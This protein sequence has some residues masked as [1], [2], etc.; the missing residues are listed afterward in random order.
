MSSQIPA[1]DLGLFDGHEV[2][3]T[4]VRIT[5]AGDGLS[6]SMAIEP[7]AMHIGDKKYIVLECDVVDVKF[8][9]VKDTDRLERV[10]TL[11]AGIAT[12]VDHSVVKKVLAA[13]R[14]K[15]EEAAGVQRIEG[16]E[17]PAD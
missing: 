6:S 11:K 15:L 3:V 10:H 17:E 13:Q 8:R 7:E 1:I 4:S 2:I 16:F 12:S 9:P 14:V 5:N